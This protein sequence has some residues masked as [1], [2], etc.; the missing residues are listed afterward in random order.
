MTD[1]AVPDLATEASPATRAAP[2]DLPQLALRPLLVIAGTL[3]VL[4]IAFSDRYGYHRDEL[5]F[6]Q[7]GG[8]CW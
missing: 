1:G 7:T 2:P 3:T 6:L 4:L 5:Y 8:R